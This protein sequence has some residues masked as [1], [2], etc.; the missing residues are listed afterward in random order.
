MDGNILRE[1][2]QS[3]G[4]QMIEIAKKL[5]ISPQNLQSKLKSK[6]ITLSFL[7]DL[8]VAI[9]KSPYYLV[10]G[11]KYA[12]FFNA[13]MIDNLNEPKASHINDELIETQRELLRMKDQRILELETKLAKKSGKRK[14]GS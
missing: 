11:T 3:V 6:D 9:N 12:K 7:V 8:S 4:L 1:K 14:T 10:S 2:L 13:D 5:D